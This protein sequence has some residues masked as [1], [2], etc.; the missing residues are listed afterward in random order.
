[1]V[2]FFALWCRSD[3]RLM[4]SENAFIIQVEIVVADFFFVISECIVKCRIQMIIISTNS[5]NVPSMTVFDSFLR[6]VTADC[7][8]TPDPECIA[9]H[10]H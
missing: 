9:Q 1:M 5:H 10:F 4:I 2:P 6:I 7:D 3:Q 8:H